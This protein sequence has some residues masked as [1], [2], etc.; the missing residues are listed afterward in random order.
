MI[1]QRWQPDPFPKWVT[2]VPSNNNPHLVP[3]YA[4]RLADSLDLEFIPCVRKVSENQ[5]QKKMENTEQQ[6][7]N[8]DGVFEVTD[9][10]VPNAPVLLVDD[11]VDSRWTLTVVTA[12]LKEAEAGPVYPFAL[13]KTTPTSTT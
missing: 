3:E 7:R 2:C 10:Q 5:P 13:A 8:L 12:L 1:T 4:E 6:T 9:R 11:T